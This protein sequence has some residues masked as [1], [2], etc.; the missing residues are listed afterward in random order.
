MTITN[1]TMN[2][3]NNRWAITVKLLGSFY[4]VT[5]KDTTTTSVVEALCKNNTLESLADDVENVVA[6]MGGT[7]LDVL[8]ARVIVAKA[9]TE[10]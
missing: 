1:L 7:D 8:Q 10:R 2:T 9:W 4:D 5:V 3:T 6:R